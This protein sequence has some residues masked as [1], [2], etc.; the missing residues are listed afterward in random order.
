MA[1][2]FDARKLNRSTLE[3]IRIQVIRSINRGISIKEVCQIFGI[4]RSKVYEWIKRVEENG[5]KDLIAKI[6][7]GKK[8]LIN[9]Q[10]KEI[11]EFWLCIFTPLDFGFDTVLWT[12]KIIKV[13]IEQ[14]F[15]ISLSRSA[16]NRLL[17]RIGLTPQRPIRRAVERNDAPVKDWINKKFLEIKRLAKE[18]GAK[19]Y[20]LDEAGIR[21]DYHAGTTWS[22]KGLTPIIPATGGRYRINMITAITNEGEMYFQICSES[23]NGNTFIEYLKNFVK[24]SHDPIFIIMD[25]HP[26]HRSKKVEEYVKNTDGLEIFFLPAYS[27]ILNPVELLWNNVKAQG[28]AH[29]LIRNVE[30]LKTKATQLLKSLK[31]TPEKIRA[32]FKEE[33]VR[34]AL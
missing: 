3:Y 30:K 22:L 18:K 4:S 10:Q 13:L 23:L 31:E 17:H 12:T 8:P 9:K 27:P 32:F 1:K 26:V 28:L 34:Y 6:A 11:L 33:F 20:F 25:G 5:L 16:V 7:P 21:T 14:K 15:E 2:Y 19:I 24:D 29:Y